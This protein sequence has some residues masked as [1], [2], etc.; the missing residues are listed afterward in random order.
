[1]AQKSFMN[2]YYALR[3]KQFSY[4]C[5]QLGSDMKASSVP[6][7]KGRVERMFETLQSRLPVELRLKGVTTLDEANEF[8]NSYIK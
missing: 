4:A 8:L 5:K 2:R 6:Q 1:M 7:A 3:K